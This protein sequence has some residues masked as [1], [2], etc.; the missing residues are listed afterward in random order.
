M[1][2]FTVGKGIDNYI[3]KLDELVLLSDEM[4]GR[5]IFEGAKI[6]TD[7]VNA[8][9]NALPVDN[10]SY[11]RYQESGT[12]SAG[13]TSAQKAGLKN[14]L[15]IARKRDDGGFI[16]V[17]VGM[18]GYNSTKSTR[19]PNGQPNAMIARS[20]ESGTSFRTKTPFI[21]TAVNAT[22]GAAEAAMAKEYDNQVRKV[23]F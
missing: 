22:R 2:R 13:I 7:K 4:I 3:D 18:D 17:K 23:G 14:G 1:A 8:N 9:I 21:S 16:N 5:A 10:R 6:V 19:W 15:G 20:I 12:A 11:K